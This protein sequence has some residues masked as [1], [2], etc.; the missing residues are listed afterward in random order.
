ML[1]NTDNLNLKG[2]VSVFIIDQDNNKTLLLRKSNLVVYT[3]REWVLSSLCGVNNTNI[4]MQSTDKLNWISFGTGGAPASDPYAPIAPQ[5]TNTTITEISVNSS[6]PL[7]Y[8]GTRIPLNTAAYSSTYQYLQD[9]NNSNMY[10]MLN[11]S[12]VL[13]TEQANGASIN[14]SALWIADTNVAATVTRFSL[15]SHVTFPTFLKQNTVQYLIQ[16]IIHS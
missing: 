5:S 1:Y 14:E 10:L 4:S 3:G 11:V 8:N 2:K 6:D 13:N 16:W 7:L 9:P 12:C 15:F